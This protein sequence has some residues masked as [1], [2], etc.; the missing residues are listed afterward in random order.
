MGNLKKAVKGVDEGIR[1]MRV[2]GVRRMLVPPSLAFVEGVGDN[3]PGEDSSDQAPLQHAEHISGFGSCQ[4]AAGKRSCF[5]MEEAEAND[6][7]L[8]CPGARL[9]FLGA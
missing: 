1:G 7:S 9:L 6:S 4:Q 2:G 3:L 8:C 5:F